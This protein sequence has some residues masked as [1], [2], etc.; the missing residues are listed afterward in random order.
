MAQ[1][2]LGDILSDLRSYDTSSIWVERVLQQADRVP[3]RCQ[4]QRLSVPMIE[5]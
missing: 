2:E 1:I 3:V 4:H 5:A